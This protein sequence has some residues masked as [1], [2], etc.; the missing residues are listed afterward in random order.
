[1]CVTP[2]LQGILLEA[3]GFVFGQLDSRGP[4]RIHRRLV[5]EA[6]DVPEDMEMGCHFHAPALLSGE[7][8]GNGSRRTVCVDSFPSVDP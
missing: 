8:E 7:T 3:F 4:G 6:G 5:D 1:M 2:C